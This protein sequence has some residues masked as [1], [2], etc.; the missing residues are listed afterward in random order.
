MADPNAQKDL[1]TREPRKSENMH[2]ERSENETML[3]ERMQ[4]EDMLEE[5]LQHEDITEERLPNENMPAAYL[6]SGNMHEQQMQIDSVAEEN[7][8]NSRQSENMPEER[9][10]GNSEYNVTHIGIGV[11]LFVCIF[12]LYRRPNCG[13]GRDSLCTC[14]RGIYEE[15]WMLTW[16]DNK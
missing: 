13:T 12:M 2:E 9:Q 5:R 14:Q 1:T 8:V 6:E 16:G 3:E 11:C 15:E 10:Q 4:N 7:K